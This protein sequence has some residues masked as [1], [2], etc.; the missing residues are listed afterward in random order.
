MKKSKI[1]I[2]VFAVM[3]AASAAR[4]EGDLV[5]FDGKK[6]APLNFS[7]LFEGGSEGRTDGAALA[8]P[9]PERVQPAASTVLARETKISVTMRTG[10]SVKKETVICEP[11]KG[12][13]AITGCRKESDSS[14]ITP[15][16][17]AAMSLRKYFPAEKTGFASLLNQTKH[18]YTNQSGP[19][20]FSCVDACGRWDWSITVSPFPPFLE[21]ASWTCV[22]DSHE[23]ECIAGCY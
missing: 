14:K 23:C 20:T 4:A 8:V 19:Q 13:P 12:A 11:A 22:E 15:E 5:D 7:E 18:P 9:E 10:N 21:E 16:D 3:V 1:L 17:V 2:A 6:S